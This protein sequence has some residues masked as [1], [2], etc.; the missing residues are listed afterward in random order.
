MIPDSDIALA[1]AEQDHEEWRSI[2][3]FEG[4]YEVSD[5]GRVRSVDRIVRYSDGRVRVH[6]GQLIAAGRDPQRGYLSIN[7]WRANKVTQ[8]KVHRLVATAF[9]GVP[10]VGQWATHANFI[11]DDNERSNIG[12]STPKQRAEAKLAARCGRQKIDRQTA[13]SIRS[14]YLSGERQCHLRREFDLSQG[15]MSA[16]CRGRSWR[17]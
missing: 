4:L 17:A 7:L 11:R 10:L 8:V 3:N 9:V 2:P 14:R 16:I 12:W 6:K 1:R 15:Q 5:L 13:I